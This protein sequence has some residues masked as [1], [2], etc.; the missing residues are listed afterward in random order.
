MK[1]VYAIPCEIPDRRQFFAAMAAFVPRG[2]G[3]GTRLE[4]S[5]DFEM[6][7]RLRKN[8]LGPGDVEP[9]CHQYHSGG[10][11]LIQKGGRKCCVFPCRPRIGLDEEALPCDRI[12]A[13]E[14]FHVPPVARDQDRCLGEG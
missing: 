7:E 6:R 1:R 10:V 9:V 11:E 14:F 13:K 5:G 4:G 2:E 8:R 12:G 3:M